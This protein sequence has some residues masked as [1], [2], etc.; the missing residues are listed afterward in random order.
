MSLVRQR[1]GK[2]LFLKQYAFLLLFGDVYV[3]YIAPANLFTSNYYLSTISVD[4]YV[5]KL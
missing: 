3:I 4:N 1:L 5:G 2:L